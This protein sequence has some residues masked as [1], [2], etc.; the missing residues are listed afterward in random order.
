MLSLSLLRF[1]GRYTRGHT[2]SDW[3]KEESECLQ[4]KTR[5]RLE[6]AESVPGWGRGLCVQ[7]E[8]AQYGRYV[9]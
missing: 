4:R 2:I 5:I 6:R 1:A 3:M 8:E 7:V 9:M